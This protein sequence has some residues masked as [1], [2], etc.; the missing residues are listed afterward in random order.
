MVGKPYAAEIQVRDENDLAISKAVFQNG[1]PSLNS[2][3]IRHHSWAA[4]ESLKKLARQAVNNFV[5]NR[6]RTER[7]KFEQQLQ[8]GGIFFEPGKYALRGICPKLTEPAAEPFGLKFIARGFSLRIAALFDHGIEEGLAKV[9]AECVAPCPTRA[10]TF[11][12]PDKPNDGLDVK[13][14]SGSDQS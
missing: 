8:L 1:F 14:Q 3:A 9:G 11:A 12:K 5:A 6:F 13:I 7:R 4:S 10:L 2:Q